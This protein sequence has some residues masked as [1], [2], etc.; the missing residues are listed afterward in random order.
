MTGHSEPRA[1]AHDDPDYDSP[2]YLRSEL[3]YYQEQFEI[4]R[5]LA[6]I[7]VGLRFID[8]QLDR[9]LGRRDDY[10]GRCERAAAMLRDL[11]SAEHGSTITEADRL[12]QVLD[13]L[14][15]ADTRGGG[16]S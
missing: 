9:Q 1:T 7:Q 15:G 6:P 5:G 11:L 13:V 3:D 2:E 14:Q 12:S 4:V 10:R 8:E 16:A